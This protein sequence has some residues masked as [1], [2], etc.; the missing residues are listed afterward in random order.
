M[1]RA[2]ADA[3]ALHDQSSAEVEELVRAQEALSEKYREEAKG[4]ATRSEALVVE[5]RAESERLSIRCAELSAQLA[6]TT[7]KNGSLDRGDRE[8]ATQLAMLQKQ[9]RIF[10][11]AHFADAVT[12]TPTLPPTSPRPPPSPRPS[13]R[14]HPRPSTP[15]RVPVPL[16]HYV[17]PSLCALACSQLTEVQQARTQQGQLITQLRAAESSWQSERR[18]LLRQARADHA[19]ASLPAPASA[20]PIASKARTAAALGEGAG[21]GG[22]ARASA[23]QE[24]ED[25]LASARLAE[26]AQR[27]Q[28]A[29]KRA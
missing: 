24:V 19:V 23:A 29:A 21:R 11:Y 3:R 22:S 18:V 27:S 28:A 9:A 12:P 13:D 6:A 10:A 17:C 15:L 4:I 1:Q 20:Q 5:L 8:K 25:A 26:A 2:V 14:R 16:R 7:A